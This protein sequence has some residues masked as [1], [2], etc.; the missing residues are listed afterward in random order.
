MPIL[1]ERILR[2]ADQLAWAPGFDEA[3]AAQLAKDIQPHNGTG[4]PPN[5]RWASSLKRDAG[6]GT[7]LSR[8]PQAAGPGTQA[9]VASL[10]SDSVMA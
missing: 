10:Q 3:M 2:G 8:R 4:A 7:S 5:R 1:T 9:P 6:S